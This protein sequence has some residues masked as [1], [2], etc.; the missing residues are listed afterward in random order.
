MGTADTAT[1]HD[2]S[3]TLLGLLGEADRAGIR[4]LARRHRFTFQELRQVSEAAVDL[5][6]WQERPLRD[7]WAAQ[8]A[9]LD[10]AGR[11]LKKELFRR[12]RSRLGELRGA[13]NHYPEAGLK[14]PRNG[15]LVLAAESSE[16]QLLGLCPVASEETVC[17]NL[18]TLDA[19]TSCG[20]GCSYCTIQTFYDE[21]IVFDPE[22]GAKLRALE[23]DPQRF[24]HIGTGQSSDSLMW[25]NRHGVLDA[26]CDFAARRPN[27]VLEL[28][29]KAAN[30]S[31]FLERQVPRN[32][33]ISW[34]LNPPAV[35]RNEEH[36]TAPLHKRLR[37]ARKLADH[38]VGVAFHFHPIVHYDDYAAD[39]RELSE[40]VLGGF[41]ASE[42]VFMS[43]GTL[44]FIK[45]VV[46][47]IRQRRWA[48]K[49]LQMDLVPGAKGKLTYPAPLK[50]EMFGHL[51]GCFA[52]W[53][54]K[55]F[56]YLC[57]EEARFWHSTFS[58]AYPDND[59]FES[60][61][62]RHMRAKLGLD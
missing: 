30:V 58:F 5:E 55:V 23:L 25:G 47:A 42:V 52:P 59:A 16:R 49:I 19:V 56:M 54:G 46:R 11:P 39:Y 37:A 60:D 17:C 40:R 35:I 24:Y 7:W 10:L 50:E 14:A 26:L 2:E 12:L 57:M 27:V 21:R 22:L 53:H 13:P 44:T 15:D 20:F 28:K 4:A 61:F 6:A 29:T 62:A 48:T 3:R 9:A 41:D 34:S 33:L 45:P 43:F 38:G 1:R 18:R 51:H 8:E 32:L 31:Y 36:F